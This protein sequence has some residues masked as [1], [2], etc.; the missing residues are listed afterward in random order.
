MNPRRIT[1]LVAV[2][3]LAFAAGLLLARLL[4]RPE[5]APVTE[6]ATVLVPPRELPPI[7]LLDADSR[8]FT[9]ARFKGGWTLVFFGFAR[10]PDVCPTTLATLA[11][12]RR[13]LADL[14]AGQLPRVLLVTVDP[15]RDTPEVLGPYVRHFDPD[16]LAATGSSAQVR[17]VTTAFGV[18][19]AKVSVGDGDY[20]MDHGSALFMVDPQGRLRAV[21]SAP[22]TAAVIARDFRAVAGLAAGRG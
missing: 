11:Q 19:Y 12:V 9:N 14:P 16:F 7:E 1:T 20:T 8:P 4:A 22:H 13:E 6:R 2:L 5:P 10:C 21:M 15:E 17:A 3:I 18:P